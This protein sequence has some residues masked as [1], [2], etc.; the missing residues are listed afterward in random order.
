MMITGTSME[1]RL[2][3]MGRK[4]NLE[5]ELA[6][7]SAQFVADRDRKKFYAV[8]RSTM[9]KIVREQAAFEAVGDHE[10]ENDL[11][12]WKW[13][14]GD[15]R[16]APLLAALVLN[17]RQPAK[18]YARV[19]VPMRLNRFT[20]FEK[21]RYGQRAAVTWIDAEGRELAGWIFRT[22]DYDKEPRYRV[23]VPEFEDSWGEALSID[24]IEPDREIRFL[25]RS[26]F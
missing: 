1:Q 15:I 7:A 21:T 6:V 20:A 2:E 17:Y 12:R 8:V 22:S 13:A 24:A 4:E 23:F 19:R 18:G 9:A 10:I 16:R 11:S 14:L 26:V 3:I 25:E 5:E